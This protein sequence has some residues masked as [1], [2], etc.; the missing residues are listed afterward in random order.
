MDSHTPFPHTD[1]SELPLPSTDYWDGNWYYDYETWINNSALEHDDKMSHISPVMKA[2]SIAMYSIALLVGTTGNG[3]V[4]FLTAFHMKKT[5]TTTWYLNLAVADYVFATCLLPEII[6]QAL[7]YHWPLG[8]LMCKL[9]AVV[10]FLNMFASVFFLTAI[11]VDRYLIMVH[12]VWS[13]NHRTVH[14]A[15]FLAFFIW[16]SALVLSLPYFSFR[17]TV[18]DP[19]NGTIQCTYNHNSEHDTEQRSD[20]RRPMVLAEFVVGFLIPF[21]IILACYG[22]L[23]CHLR[24][25]LL[26]RFNRSFK[27]VVAVVVAFFSCWFPFHV[28]AILETLEDKK[29]KAIIDIGAPLANGLVCFNSCLNPMLYAF[30]SPGYR[31]I[32]RQF[33]LYSFK[34]AFEEKWATHSSSSTKTPSFSSGVESTKI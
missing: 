28:F 1:N 15:S 30:V 29:L 22:A 5:V 19:W 12:P 14:L 31:K 18:V 27:V 24:G 11:S 13:L 2:V 23:L 4:I 21:A 6:Y 17:D 25:K 9:D 26:G 3:L 34:G 16:G 33:L 32:N 7:D 10:P 8:R 20:W